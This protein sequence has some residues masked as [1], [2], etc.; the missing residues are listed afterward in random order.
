MHKLEIDKARL[1]LY[2]ILSLLF[3]EEYVKNNTE[4]LISDLEILSNNSFDEDVA[5]AAKEIVLYLKENGSDKLYLDY[6]E[7]FIVP[8]GEFISLSASWYHEQREGGLMQ[9]KVRDILAK[10]KIRKDEKAFSAPE[11]HYGFIFT[12]S[13]Y[14]I[15]QQIKNEI[16]EDLQKEL[17]K[18]VINLY[19]DELFYKLI[20]SSSKI[21]SHVGLI[22]AN[23]CNFERVYLDISKIKN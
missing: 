8:F 6:Q 2:N 23:V 7:L 14:L 15:D 20:G 9:L 18:T 1:F 16:K 21:Y 11:D 13:T 17:F 3:V 12:L 22:L 4:Q 19:C 5:V 10:T